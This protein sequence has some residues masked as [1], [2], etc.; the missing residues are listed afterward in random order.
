MNS[1]DSSFES[2]T[3]SQSVSAISVGNTSSPNNQEAPKPTA[4]R[5]ATCWYFFHYPKDTS[6]ETLKCYYCKKL[7]K[8]N[9]ASSTNLTAHAKKH[10]KMYYDFE[11]HSETKCG[12]IQKEIT[13]R[14]IPRYDAEK[15]HDFLVQWIISDSQAFRAGENPFFMQFLESLHFDYKALKKDAVIQRTMKA[16]DVVKQKISD[17]LAKH[18][19]KLSLTLDIWTSPSQD[20]FLCVT[21]HFIDEKW[22]LLSQ[23]IAFRYKFQG[24]IMVP[25]LRQYWRIF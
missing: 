22:V 23:V 3:P 10:R 25:K 7:V 6:V 24:S 18:T 12:S 19:Q 1:Q 21:L 14:R 5:T 11:N 15:S 20:P 13:A 2:V 16:F 4:S 9:K 17:S 8:F